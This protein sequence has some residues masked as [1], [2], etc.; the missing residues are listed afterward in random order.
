MHRDYTWIDQVCDSSPTLT[1]AAERLGM[2]LAA[3]KGIRKRLY[4]L[5]PDRPRRKPGRKPTLPRKLAV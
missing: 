5:D 3:L 4:A 1:V 2:T